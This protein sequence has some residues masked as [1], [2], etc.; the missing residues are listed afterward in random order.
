MASLNPSTG[1]LTT[2]V[3]LPFTGVNNGGGTT[4]LKF[5][6]SPDG[7][8]LVAVGN[9][10]AVGGQPRS[11]IAMLD[12]SGPTATV[13]DWSTDRFGNVCASVFN[14][15]MRD[16]DFSPNGSYFVISTTGAYGGS[17]TL[18]DTITRWETDRTGSG[19][20]P[21]WANYTGGDTTYA[22][23][24][25]GSAVYAG[26]H[27]RWVN[28]PFAGDAAGP[29][30]VPREGIVALDPVTGLPFTW[31]PG[32]VRGV[33]VFDMLATP[34]GLWV[35]SDTRRIA[36]E[37][38][39][40]IALMP[41]AG[42]LAVPNPTAPT[43]PGTVAQLGRLGS[44]SD[45][46][47]LY[48]V[49][50]GGPLLL[51]V[52]DG[53]DWE[54]DNDSA[55]PY[56]NEGSAWV[57]AW[58]QSV[59]RDAGLPSS[60]TDRVPTALFDSERWDP[61]DDN[62]MRWNF[63]VAEGTPIT[64]RLYFANQCG[65]TSG[66]GSRVFDVAVDGTERLSDFDM[67]ALKGDRVAFMESFDLTADANGLDIEFA[68][69]VENPLVNGIE[70]IDRSVP[71]GTGSD[72]LA[73]QVDRT[74]LA[75]DGTVGVSETAA[76]TEAWSRARGAFVANNVLYTPWQDGTLRARTI[77][78]NGALGTPRTVNLYS[79]TFGTDAPNV[80]G[81]VYEPTD[82]RI[83]YT[84]AGRD[85]LFWRW[86]L[87]QSEV[88]GA[89]RFEVDAGALNGYSVRGMFLDG[90][91]LYFA[92]RSSG[93]LLKT[94]LVDGAVGGSADVVDSTRDWAAPG[95]TLLD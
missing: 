48:R 40:R 58:N 35:A 47:V 12:T 66:V 67:V 63:P 90:E 30:A 52:D 56:R 85:R 41:L 22:V 60:D 95:L 29:G 10:A 34:Q 49:N 82:G 4:I 73:D 23:T 31:N 77:G 86:F 65:C 16:V 17:E 46:S 75:A 21:T 1:A 64:L 28:N 55:S 15:Y 13:A 5:E 6:V 37:T 91:T 79:G 19:Q 24:A 78:T 80:T 45:P 38:R 62:E 57:D 18:C 2:A 51:S 69:V 94:S 76:G 81:I 33:G 93:D 87:P 84:L 32:R 74:P 14:T 11:Q 53:P 43:L 83:Y 36:G 7:S 70:V 20:N 25:T 89:Q 26:G 3:N 42:G 27:M 88:V 61:G 92:D 68:H 72:P 54:R 59:T 44:A 71:A 39:E 50:A 8:R 9:F